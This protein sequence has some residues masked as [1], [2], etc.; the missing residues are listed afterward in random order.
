M[1][2]RPGTEAG[3]LEAGRDHVTAAE[4]LERLAVLANI[5]YGQWHRLRDAVGWK[6]PRR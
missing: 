3:Y 6:P 1:M 5:S 2:Y 4:F